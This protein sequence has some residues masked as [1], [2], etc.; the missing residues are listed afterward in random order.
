M[1]M[2]CSVT[3]AT[4]QTLKTEHFDRDPNWDALNNRA[5]KPVKIRQDFGY[6]DG[7]LGG[8]ITIA[9]EPAWYAKPIPVLTL[10]Q[11][12]SASGKL[13]CK[14]RPGMAMIGFFNAG[15]TNAWRTPNS[16]ALRVHCRGERFFVY[17]E[18]CTGRWRAGSNR[19][20]GPAD[21]QRDLEAGFA[22]GDRAYEWSLK[23]D[24]QGNDGG[25][26]ITAVI[27]GLTTITPLNPGHKQDGA[28]LNRFGLFNVMKH[29]DEEAEVWIGDLAID[30]EKQ[31]LSSDPKWEARHNRREYESR[32]KRPFSDY[33]FS[34][35]HFA[36]GKAKGELGGLTFRG[37]IRLPDGVNYIGDRLEP[38]NLDKPLKA[39]G[40]IVYRRG[41]QDSSTLIGFFHLPTSVTINPNAPKSPRN[42]FDY[43]P[44]NFCG[45]AVKG[46]TR[47][48]Y[49]FHPTYRVSADE[50]GGNPG[51]AIANCPR[52]NPDGIA[53]DWSFEYDPDAAGGKGA[54]TVTLDGKSA[55]LELKE[56]HKSAGATF[57]RFGIVSNWVDGNGQVVYLDDVTYTFKQ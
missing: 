50:G 54:I 44:R 14:D 1:G 2:L 21:K 13:V 32:D 49:F 46:P 45:V 35:T 22:S 6:R 23:Y 52:L 16:I 57:N 55:V 3:M 8:A 39:S 7:R 19:F 17:E 30:S 15:T 18:Y 10:D 25:G 28:K 26:T 48:G 33:G 5:A 36:G 12:I 40:R 4:A 38:L 34:D 27:D 31:D 47:E 53:R 51:D 11:P 37:D 56:G 9:G 43:L 20:T 41:V 29:A 42:W 24:P